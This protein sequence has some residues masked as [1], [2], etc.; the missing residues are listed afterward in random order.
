MT[1]SPLL[2]GDCITIAGYYADGYIV[3]LKES[4]LSRNHAE[5]YITITG[6]H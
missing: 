1:L 3:T 6:G 2:S 4:S 5:T